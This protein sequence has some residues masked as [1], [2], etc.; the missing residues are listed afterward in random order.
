MN[1]TASIASNSFF[2][3]YVMQKFRENQVAKE[4]FKLEAKHV[5][6]LKIRMSFAL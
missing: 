2:K 5:Y 1:F 6:F 3:I 4:E